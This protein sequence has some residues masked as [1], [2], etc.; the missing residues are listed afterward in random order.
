MLNTFK[1]KALKE[2]PK[3][4]SVSNFRLWDKQNSY[5]I[6]DL[7][8]ASR[9]NL[10]ISS[11][12]QT[13]AKSTQIWYF[14]EIKD[15]FNANPDL[16]IYKTKS[17]HI[18]SYL[19]S[20][21]KIGSLK[22]REKIRVCLSSLY[23]FCNIS[24]YIDNNPVSVIK[25]KK[26]LD[27]LYDKILEDDEIKMM[28]EMTSKK[29]DQIFIKLLALT[30]IRVGGIRGI[31][32]LDIKKARDGALIEVLEKGFKSRR[33]FVNK[34]LYDEIQDLKNPQ[35]LKEHK[36]FSGNKII[37]NQVPDDFYIF[38]SQKFPFTQLTNTQC[39]EI[40][41]NA[42][43]RAKLHK[44]VSPHWFRHT[45]ATRLINN[46]V[47]VH[48]VKQLLGHSTIASTSKYLHKNY[49]E[50]SGDVLSV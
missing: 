46:E 25:S 28:I 12:L 31:R 30:G 32:F 6:D 3:E 13:K 10:L 48:R 33:V 19:E 37:P 20:I 47:P 41:K 27:T 22:R 39:Y 18:H 14:K 26:T 49:D 45:Y 40:V 50:F 7:N 23:K 2:S 44:K 11:W 24:N 4:Y 8:R 43:L 34:K 17:N 29:R 35:T 9:E 21:E 36:F 5:R 1:S 15:F 42:A 38:R 16:M